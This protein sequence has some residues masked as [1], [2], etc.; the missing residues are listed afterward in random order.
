MILKTI[1][2]VGA[3]TAAVGA[4]L[5]VGWG[6]NKY[7]DS[8]YAEKEDIVLAESKIEKVKAQT[9]YALDRQISGVQRD[10]NYLEAKRVKTADDRDTIKYLREQL[11]EMKE[12][13]SG[14]K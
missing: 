1:A 7:L 5:G 9:N 13:R 12:V 11:K 3:A 8:T 14:K 4:M 10:I 6:A 2:A